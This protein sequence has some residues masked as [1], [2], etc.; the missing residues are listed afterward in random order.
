MDVEVL[1]PHAGGERVV[2]EGRHG[3]QRVVAVPSMSGVVYWVDGGGWY[4]VR[5]SER[6]RQHS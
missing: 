5:E 1:T 3:G 6:R 2:D 4:I